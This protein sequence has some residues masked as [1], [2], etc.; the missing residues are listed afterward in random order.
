M[1]WNDDDDLVLEIDG[2]PSIEYVLG[3]GGFVIPNVPATSTL[4][5]YRVTPLTQGVAFPTNTTPAAE[6]V[7]AS[8]DKLTFIVQELAALAGVDLTPYQLILAEGAFA[9]GDKAKLDGIAPNATIDQ[10]LSSYQV[11][12]A[13]GAFADGDKTKLDSITL[14]AAGNL[15]VTGTAS[16]QGLSAVGTTGFEGSLLLK[17]RSNSTYSGLIRP[18]N[19]TTFRNF[20]LPDKTGTFALLD[21]V[22]IGS[23]TSPQ[24]LTGA[25]A[26]SV[27]AEATLFTSDAANNSI[28][29]ADGSDR[30]KKTVVHVASSNSGTGRITATSKTGFV[31]VTLVGLGESVTFQYFTASG[32]VIIGSHAAT[33]S[34]GA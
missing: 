15:D 30:Q 25:G 8:F 10:D 9:D 26:I 28:T 12:P 11:K 16:A 14:S 13:E 18:S 31:N 21:D 34:Y 22:P 2:S 32:W 27:L 5:M 23:T 29:L 19:F 6:D 20:T 24:E 3:G 17:Y 4:I 7:S 1:E 33:I